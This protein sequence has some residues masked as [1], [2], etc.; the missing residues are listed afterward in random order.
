MDLNTVGRT[1]IFL[2]LALALL[3]GIL[4]LFSRVPFLKDLGSL[5]GDVRVEGKNFSCFFPIVS[6]IIISVLLSLALNIILR[7]LNR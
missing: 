6:M 4:M 5:P 1:V 2:G 3:G 7:L